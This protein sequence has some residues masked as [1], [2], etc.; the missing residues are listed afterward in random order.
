MSALSAQAMTGL[1]TVPYRRGAET[2][3]IPFG[4]DSSGST[5]IAP[6]D[7]AEYRARYDA[8]PPEP[9]YI[10]FPKRDIEN[11]VMVIE[12]DSV[13]Q[14]KLATGIDAVTTTI[15]VTAAFGFPPFPPF[16][17]RLDNEVMTVGSMLAVGWTVTRGANG[18]TPAAHAKGTPV[19]FITPFTIPAGSFAGVSFAIPLPSPVSPALRLLRLR[20]LPVPLPGAGADNWGIVALLGNLAKLTWV[21]GWEKDIIRRHFE[22]VR[23]QRDITH[24]RS[25]SL[26][27][28][29]EDLRVPRFPPREHSFD[30]NTVALYHFNDLVPDG[31]VVADETKRLGLPGHPGTN[32]GARS[33]MAGK[34]GNGFRFPGLSGSGRI[35]IAH[36]VDFD[37][38][39]DGSFTIEAFVKADALTDPSDMAPHI[40]IMKRQQEIAGP[41]ALA[42]WSL[43]LGNFRGIPNNVMWA[44]AD[45]VHES[46]IFADLSFVDGKFHHLA[47]MVDRG[48]RRARLF[49]D[50]EQVASADISD[51]GA[52]KNTEI[53]RIGSGP[54]GN[55]F[56]GVVDELRWSNVARPDFHP[57]LGEG[58]SAYRQRLAV[59]ERWHL[60]TPN[61]LS[62]TINSLVQV[63]GEVTSFVLVEKNR[64][65]ATASKVIRILPAELQRGQSI[66]RDGN[67]RS[68]E[69]DVSG[70]PEHDTD[71]REIYLLRHS[72]PR[73]NYGG[74][75][76]N[77][78]MQAATQRA[79]N[80]LLDLLSVAQIPG[81]LIIDKSFDPAD[82]GLH[83][84]GRALQLRHETL[85]PS[86]LANL[87]HRADFDFV[88]NDGTV[89][90]ASVA[91]GEK[92]EIVVEP[93]PETETPLPGSDVLR[94]NKIA[95]HVAPGSLPSVGQFEWTLIACGPG[96]AHF[97]TH[98]SDPPPQP[99]SPVTSRPRLALVADSPGKI[100]V[101][102]EYT[103]ERGTVSGTRT[104]VIGLPSLDDA[105]TIAAD[106]GMTVTEATAAGKPEP[107]F[108]AIYL[109]VHPD[110][111]QVDFGA[112][113]NN[114]KMQILLEKRLD[115]LVNLLV[116]M[117]AAGKLKV[118]KAFDPG[119]AGLHKV[120]RAARLQHENLDI[121]KL[122]ALASLAGF[123]FVRREGTQIYCSVAAGEKIEIVHADGVTPLEETLTADAAMD[124]QVRP[125]ALPNPATVPNSR[126]VYNWSVHEI[127][128]GRGGFDFVLRAKVAFMPREPGLLLLNAMYIEDDL[129][130]TLPYTFE[131]RLKDSLNK[132]STFIPKHQYDLILNILN[133][134]H[135]TGVQVG[136]ENI[137]EH[138][139]EIETGLANAFPG[140]TYP[141]FQ[142]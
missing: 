123:E 93:P 11:D 81:K 101:R 136:T 25:F 116:K 140:Y 138:V 113:A 97:D 134:F 2:L 90:H 71:F 36:A 45:G 107:D 52:I 69:A 17:I 32:I 46:K 37:V 77:R 19:Q 14:G 8:D 47:G 21:L 109:V 40:I 23:Q 74:N 132:P 110:V 141:D 63:M 9:K 28:L 104:A 100:V 85:Q 137:R 75:E 78:R 30:A 84:V 99:S 131:I 124:L 7:F 122:G 94:G 51:M 55:Q 64:P 86:K 50:G 66:D 88:R 54:A 108:N 31:A 44:V 59:F 70:V 105:K 92:L 125:T 103:F 10:L 24:A 48:K 62:Q 72:D 89:L 27:A 76:N 15:A 83:L 26:D 102:V 13:S 65:S 73:V 60:P 127:G 106:G 68:Q 12:V 49:V 43:S 128:Y 67:L 118:I 114:K 115:R 4:S 1:V 41:Q 111:P 53:V 34:F 98:P 3:L 79:V 39:A 119:D 42:G 87:A 139:V 96:R 126:A 22:D 95:L 142:S 133:Y 82:A 130:G 112:D 33:S 56:S 38:P 129:T 120:G 135:P 18:T 29:G 6:Y 35:E 117:G 5:N 57:V 20:Q 16:R 58:D 80:E 121:G 61:A 91:Q